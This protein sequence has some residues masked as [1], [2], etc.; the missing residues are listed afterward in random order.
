MVTRRSPTI[1]LQ[2]IFTDI[3][4]KVQKV[5]EL[6]AEIKAE[7]EAAPG[8]K[9]IVEDQEDVNARKMTLREEIMKTIPEAFKDLEEIQADL[10]VEMG[11]F[12]EKAIPL[13]IQG[14]ELK[15]K[16]EKGKEYV[17]RLDVKILPM[18][19]KSDQKKLEGGDEKE[20]EI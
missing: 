18:G 4:F 7:F 19:E 16:G 15:L 1:Q 17:A 12:R 11:R 10:A 20:K 2:F 13:L 5:R 3:D 9:K 14:K 6:K 8:W